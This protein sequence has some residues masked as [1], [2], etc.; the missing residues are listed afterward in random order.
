MEKFIETF[1]DSWGNKITL[2][3]GVTD[4][5]LHISVVDSFKKPVSADLD[6]RNVDELI[7]LLQKYKKERML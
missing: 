2:V 6:S 1:T 3:S 4:S 7:E 5:L